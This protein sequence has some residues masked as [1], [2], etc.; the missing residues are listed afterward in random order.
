MMKTDDLIALLSADTHPGRAVFPEVLF[1]TLGPILVTGSVFLMVLG[2]RP[3]LTSAVT[4]QVAVW[5]WLL[6]GLLVVAGIALALA[7]SRPES[8]P[9]KAWW[10]TLLAAAIGAALFASRAAILPPTDW[11]AAIRGRTLLVCLASIS[12]IGLT[13]LVGGLAILRRGA[14]TRPGLSGLALGLGSGGA[15]ALLYALHCNEDDPM[16][17]V[18]WYGSAIL[19]VGLIG[20]ISGQR[21]LRM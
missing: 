6:P 20:A 4:S 2:I 8:G 12:T 16:F 5:K 14:T 15:A 19:A 11:M 17:F 3:D 9:R 7:L 21:W 1:A 13:G 18:T 10:V